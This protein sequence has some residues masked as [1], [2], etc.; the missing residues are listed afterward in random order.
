MTR[1]RSI[2][3]NHYTGSLP[4]RLGDPGNLSEARRKEFR[5]Y[6][7]WL[8]RMQLKHNIMLYRQDLKGF[9][10]PAP[11]QWDG[12]QRINS[13]TRAG[14]II[15]VFKQNGLE[16]QRLITVNFLDPGKMY[17]VKEAVTEK[18]VATMSGEIMSTKGFIVKL[19]KPVDS[20]LF[21]ISEVKQD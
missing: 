19:E 1:W 15:G 5:E 13:D 17:I 9:G 4:I 3:L 16:D 14:G 18:T 8:Q 12:F 11:K 21:E 6:S 2:H 20:K 7:Q 10:E